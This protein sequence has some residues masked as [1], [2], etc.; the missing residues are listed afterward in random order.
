MGEIRAVG[1]DRRMRDLNLAIDALH[2]LASNG[3]LEDANSPT[4][5]AGEHV[6]LDTAARGVGP[7]GRVEVPQHMWDAWADPHFERAG[8]TAP[9]QPHSNCPKAA[10]MVRALVKDGLMEMAGPRDTPNA[11][12]FVK[13]KSELKAALIMNM[14]VFNHTCEAGHNPTL[15]YYP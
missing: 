6:S 8:R 10:A 11:Q 13:Y 5:R 14:V 2:V 3:P 7:A 4:L 9:T 15:A 1:V 12:V